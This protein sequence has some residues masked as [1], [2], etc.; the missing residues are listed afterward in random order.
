M[1]L[2]AEL[3]EF[4]E[5][6]K[7]AGSTHF[8]MLPSDEF[9]DLEDYID[10]LRNEIQIGAFDVEV[11]GGA[12]F[13][14][15]MTEVEVFL[16]FSE[17]T[18]ETQKRDVIQARG[19]SMSSLTWRD[20]IVKLLSSKAHS[21]L[22]RSVQYVGERI[23]WFFEKQKEA[24]VEF[25]GSLDG[26]P[27]EQMFSPLYTKHAK[28]L[29]QNDVIRQ[30]VFQTYDNACKRQLSNFVE[31]FENMLTSTFSNPWVFLKGAGGA[32]PGDDAGDALPS[33]DETKELI[34]SEIQNRTGF[35]ASLSKWLHEI[36]SDPAQIDEAVEKVQM[37]VLKTY[38]FIRSQ[39]CDQVEL[40]AESFFKLPMM[41]RLEGDMGSIS[42]SDSDKAGYQARRER[43]VTD[44][45]GSKS[46]LTEVAAC[47]DR[48]Q[49]FK[50][51]CDSRDSEDSI[52][53]AAKR[54]RMLAGC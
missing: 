41:R 3:R 45:Q 18:A 49:K 44:V 32:D 8:S 1:T 24:V 35:E 17:I 54:A 20:V 28:L 13:R 26:T 15:M 38:G 5:F 51:K 19:V 23:R 43:L 7:N 47:I 25:M 14:R 36:P 52:Q 16:R 33:F 27:G 42:L 4:H 46:S 34:P 22:Q 6:H 48:L 12:Q 31:L 39:V 53:H 37:L 30:M 50:A 2:E 21:P 11:N 29:K 40:F 9:S 10:Y